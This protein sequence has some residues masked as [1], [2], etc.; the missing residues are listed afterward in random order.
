[1]ASRSLSGTTADT[2]SDRLKITRMKSR[3]GRNPA[4]RL[5]SSRKIVCRLGDFPRVAEFPLR[6]AAPAGTAYLVVEF[7]L[8]AG[9][10]RDEQRH[11][12]DLAFADMLGQHDRDP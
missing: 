12:P 3:A 2:G 5:R 4:R 10:D 8:H 7:D 6:A 9:R 11:D 1:M